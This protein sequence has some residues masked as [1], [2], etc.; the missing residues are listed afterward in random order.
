MSL[1]C[2]LS[3]E[4]LATSSDEAVVTPSGHICLKRLLLTKL[5]ENGGMDPFHEDRPLTEDQLISLSTSSKST[6]VPPRPNQTT[7]MPGLLNAMQSEYDALVLELFDTRKALE[8]T[9]RELSQALYQ[10]D[11]AM[12]VVARM[13]MERDQ[14]RQQLQEWNANGGAA[15]AAATTT[16]DEGHSNKKR[17]M[18]ATSNG[19]GSSAATLP[20][21]NDIPEEDLSSMIAVWETLHKGRKASQKEAAASAP[22]PDELS[23]YKLAESE[24]WHPTTCKGI[25]A[26]ASC[27]DQLVTTGKDKSVFVYDTSSKKVVVSVHS[28]SKAATCVDMN[29]SLIAAGLSNGKIQV[30]KAD[31]GDSLGVVETEST[32]PAVSINLHPDGQHILA[33]LSTGQVSILRISDNTVQAVSTF[34]G[35]E[36]IQYSSGCLHPDGLIYLTGNAQG[37]IQLWDL[38]SKTMAGSLKDAETANDGAVVS[39]QV[40]NNGYHIAAAYNSGNVRVW[41][42]RKQKCIATLNQD[43]ALATV[44]CVAFD[45][46]GK[47]LALSGK[48]GAT[49]ITVKEWDKTTASLT[50][51]AI[52]SGIAWGPSLIASYS[53]NGR[54]VGFFR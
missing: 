13:A 45:P 5:T 3:G 4:M 44:T 12:R 19:D 17:K 25:T 26:M 35:T 29:E 48:G 27:G 30:W 23:Q 41:D 49:I 18:E 34:K 9:R 22:K 54:K 50:G 24:A 40:S 39:V 53:T 43:K 11:A 8:E 33:T 28:E 15:A 47:Y 20:L 16:T 2:E 7:S 32:G 6:I 21:T 51:G 1:Q 10:N 14:A 37:E 46:A 38:K 52:A 36:E 31:S 42:L